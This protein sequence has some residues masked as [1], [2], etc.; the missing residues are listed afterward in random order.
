MTEPPDAPLPAP[1]TPSPASDSLPSDSAS[2]AALTERLRVL[3]TGRIAGDREGD[4][5]TSVMRAIV[6]TRRNRDGGVSKHVSDCRAQV[7]RVW[8]EA[9]DLVMMAAEVALLLHLR[10]AVDDALAGRGRRAIEQSQDALATAFE[11][12]SGS[13]ER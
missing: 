12:V 3:R 9:E 6:L 8:A 1:E 2:V 11:A 10:G 7:E 13:Y 5:L 4:R